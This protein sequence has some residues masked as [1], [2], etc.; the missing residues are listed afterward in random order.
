M[1]LVCA[2]VFDPDNVGLDYWRSGASS[3][4][5]SRMAFERRL[6]C[7]ELILDSLSVFER[8][9]GDPSAA[10]TSLSAEELESVKDHAYKLSF[11]SD[12]EMFHSTLYDWLISRQL[13][14]D[15]LEVCGHCSLSDRDTHIVY[16][17]DLLT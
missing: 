12:D 17:Y 13:A 7:Y 2:R 8:Q 1:P 11:S 4:G 6:Q 3:D 9:M 10:G 5:P 16:R 15:L 14:D